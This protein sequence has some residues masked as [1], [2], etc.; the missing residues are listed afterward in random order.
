MNAQNKYGFSALILAAGMGNLGIVRLLTAMASV[1]VNRVESNSCS[2]LMIACMHGY[3]R[4]A[5][6]LLKVRFI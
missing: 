1:D 3:L 6:L 4:I 5:D 2:A